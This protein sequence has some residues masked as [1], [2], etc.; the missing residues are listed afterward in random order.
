MVTEKEKLMREL[1]PFAQGAFDS[2]F[3]SWIQLRPLL[4]KLYRYL[5][6]KDNDR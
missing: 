2:N 3:E 4:F 1:K 5:E 6:E